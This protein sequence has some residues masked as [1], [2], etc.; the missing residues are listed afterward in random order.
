MTTE[1]ATTAGTVAMPQPVGPSPRVPSSR[2]ASPTDA[3]AAWVRCTAC[4]TLIYRKRLRRN[5]E[6]C[7]ECGNHRRLPAPE[8]I[9]QLV[10]AG[11]FV[12]L[13]EDP[14]PDLDGDPDDPLGFVDS[15]PYPQRLAAARGR[16]GLA[17][18][19]VCGEARIDGHPVVLAVMD[20][21]FL[22]GSLGR[23]VG[24]RIVRAAE[25]AL[26]RH[27]PLVLV[28][29]SG[30]AR[31]QEGALALMQ[32]AAVSQAIATLRESGPLTISVVTDP[33]YGGVAASFATNTDIVLVESGARMGFAGP[34]VIR[35]TIGQQLPEGFQTAPFLLRHGQVDLV[36]ERHRLR[37]R[38]ASLLAMVPSA[39]AGRGTGGAMSATRTP[40]LVREPDRLAVPDAWRNV[41]RARQTD[42]PTTLDY[43]SLAFE[44]FVELHGD[45]IDA[46]CPAIVAGTA[47]LAGHGVVVIGHQK[48]HRTADLL[49]RNFGMSSPAGYRKAQRV[50]RLAVRLGL[51]V[52]TLIDTP[53]AYPGVDAERHGQAAAIADCIMTMTGLP[54]PVVAVVTGEGGSGGALALAV[55]DQVLV[56]E[57][58]VYSVISPEGCAAILW[59]DP[60]ATSSAARAL[61]LT[62]P[63]L[64][65]LGV[66][67]AVVP[68]PGQ[69]AHTDPAAA[70]ELLRQGLCEALRPL[71]DVP[72]PTLVR[73]RRQRFRRYAAV[74]NRSG[75]R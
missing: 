39:A 54:V 49:A 27:R 11:S 70:A 31:M 53:G 58:A 34:R 66:V 12:P 47:Q 48:G 19:V 21:R 46:D 20:F 43:L 55:A 45:R 37:A 22:G 32:M 5:L 29:A 71:L 28:T 7:P 51:P 18:A 50:M 35:Q 24:G 17:E 38:L 69:G 16:T 14:T 2:V 26:A 63:E 67:D 15:L 36:V 74:D 40:V 57:H 59:N 56:L 72:G 68:E 41:R 9:R 23:A 4:A 8:R 60:A 33:T 25:R 1:P 62:A 61:R 30:G 6:V 13:T 42:R 3:M 52:V 73:R 10:D 64:L 65:R 75:S 44:G